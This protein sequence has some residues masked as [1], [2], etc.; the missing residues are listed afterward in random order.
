MKKILPFLGLIGA[1]IAIT[2]CSNNITKISTSN[3]KDNLNSFTS[4]VNALP[5]IEKAIQT[6]VANKYSLTIDTPTTLELTEDNLI[7]DTSLDKEETKTRIEEETLSSNPI[8]NQ[9]ELIDNETEI[10]EETINADK[11]QTNISTLYSLSN[12]VEN[13]CNNFCQLKEELTKAI[14]ET[15]NLIE[16]VESNEVT[17]TREERLKLNEQAMQLKNLGKQLSNVSTHL[18]FNLSD[19]RQL[20]N[21]NNGDINSLSLKYLIVLDNLVNSNE[22]LQSGL[23]SLNMMN[24]LLNGG[25]KRIVYGYQENNNP[26]IIKDYTINEEGNITENETKNNID[27]YNN[28]PANANIDSYYSNNRKN[29]DS[30]FNTALLDN[31]LMYGAGGLYGGYGYGMNPYLNQY[32]QYEKNQNNNAT[33]GTTD[34]NNTQNVDNDG[35]KSGNKER[36][37][38][39]I[40]KNIDTYRDESTPDLKTKFNNFKQSISDAFGKINPENEIEHPIIKY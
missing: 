40:K 7:N 15:E 32:T 8:E 20:L 22:M 25:Q 23:L 26:P 5:E 12:D 31:E 14:A 4:S 18:A 21:E 30:F 17:L 10:E 37:K 13:G 11:E 3:T 38:F 2:G 9:Q 33:Q 6:S 36:K 27:T 19:L 16:K 29:I 34:N 24:N 39:N 28:N 35:E 1:T